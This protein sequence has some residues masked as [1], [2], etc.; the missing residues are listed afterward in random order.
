MK[1]TSILLFILLVTMGISLWGQILAWDFNT[2]TGSET[3]VNATTNS[4]N[5]ATSVISRGTGLTIPS[6][7][8]ANAFNG[9]SYVLNG[10]RSDA[11]SNNEFFQFAISANSGYKVSLST[12]DANF[13]RSGTGPNTFQWQYSLDGFSTSGVNIS[14]E[15][16]FTSTATAGV[17]QT[18]ISLS[19]ISAL[20]NVV[21][22][23]TITIRIYGWGATNVTG[24]FALG[25]PTAP[26]N[27]LAVGGSVISTSSPAPTWTTGWPKADTPATTGF[28][29][30]V[31]ISAAGTAYYVVLPNLASAPSPV[32]VKA[33]QDATG[34]GVA[35]NLKGTIPCAASNTEY[36]SPVSSL[37]SATTYDVYFVAED[38][39][40]NLQESPTK[41]SVT[42]LK[43][44][45]TNHVTSFTAGI[46]TPYTIPLTWTDAV[47]GTQAPDGYLI[48]GSSVS[49]ADIGEPTDG[50]AESDGTLKKN[51][52]QGVQYYT[53]TGLSSSTTYYFQI[54]PFTNSGI[55][56]DYKTNGT[57]P[58]ASATTAVYVAPGTPVAMA[59]LPGL[60]YTETFTAI[61]NWSNGFTSGTGASAFNS[62]AVNAT[63]TI[64]D[65]VKI[66][67]AT[68]TFV[69]S[70]SG[71]VQ[72]GTTQAVPTT[73]IVLLS[74]GATDN[75]SST[76]IDFFMDFTGVNAGILS[77]DW[78]CVFNSTG[79]RNSSLRVYYSTDGITFTELSAAQVLNFTNNVTS[80]GSITG[81]TLPSAF[82]NI[83]TARL[84]FYY[85]NATGGTNGSRPKISIDNLNVT[86]TAI[87][88]IPA[89]GSA[90]VGGGPATGGV[91][92]GSTIDLYSGP[93]VLPGDAVILLLPNVTTPTILSYSGTGPGTITITVGAGIWY[94]LIY[95]GSG[96]NQGS[97]YPRNGAGTITFTDVPFG[98]KGDVVILL[99]EG[100]DPTLPVELSSF[101]LT[102][103]SENNV[104]LQWTTQ[105]ETGVSGYYI[106]RNSSDE[107]SS[108][109]RIPAFI[110]ATNSSTETSYS[111]TDNE[112]QP[113]IWYYWLQNLDLDGQF[114]FYGPI[115]ITLTND[116]N[117][118]TPPVIPTVTALKSIFPNP[119]NPMTFISYN[120]AKAERVTLEIYN[121]KGAK[122]RSLMSESKSAGTWRSAWNGKDDN[123]QAC[124]SGMYYVKMTAGK[125]SSTQK[126]VLMK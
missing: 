36:T 95:Y 62:V 85:N 26:L 116:G 83:A 103:T 54:Y 109:M 104:M 12:L 113:G 75:S 94:G 33:G 49:Y 57:V 126:V 1:K 90:D 46:T 111:F 114:E 99:D 31:N 121:I 53:F 107:L 32:Q 40:P 96:W 30:R 20:Q 82:N 79:D 73:S 13:R 50:T 91:T 18:Q 41:V 71:G 61:A 16:S 4:S 14:S 120:L 124:T 105:S 60:S 97:P 70:S 68:S 118:I 74:T 51:V 115:S 5:L 8:A 37:S 67:A 25:R 56:I 66:T 106:Y 9:T 24:S 43:T 93:S 17:A 76:A 29:A 102:A 125:Y 45:P 44:E 86:A 23:T 47:T 123:G 58:Q 122:V 59:S 22:G 63:G 21:S 10:T 42:T 64:P 80:S 65:G 81:V 92:V 55:N 34:A 84:R 78:A 101:T 11:L 19:G 2:L 87:P 28:T 3:T 35:S 48:K 72:K 38:A 39:V 119:F 108:A 7:P 112:V 100:G 27:D 110:Q 98:A 77:F 15:I 89:G 88:A 69:T 117:Q 52:A 6:S